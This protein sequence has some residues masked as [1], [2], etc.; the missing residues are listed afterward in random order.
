LINK[1]TALKY[2]LSLFL[3]IK[4]KL[5]KVKDKDVSKALISCAIAC[6]TFSSLIFDA[7]YYI[8]VIIGAISFI[9]FFLCFRFLAQER[10]IFIGSLILLFIFISVVFCLLYCQLSLMKIEKAFYDKIFLFAISLSVNLIIANILFNK[11]MKSE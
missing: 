5:L 4:I 10:Q 2:G 6:L 3:N 11:K 1:E 8:Q 7:A 9:L